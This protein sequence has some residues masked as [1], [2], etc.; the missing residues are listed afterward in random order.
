MKNIVQVVS[1]I[2][3]KNASLFCCFL[4]RSLSDCSYCKN[5]ASMKSYSYSQKLP[6]KMNGLFYFILF[7]QQREKQVEVDQLQY[8]LGAVTRRSQTEAAGLRQK[9]SDLELQLVEARKEADEYYRSNLERNSEVTAL[10]Q[11]VLAIY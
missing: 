8:D 11:E 9:V 5:L 6:L 10:G 4:I 2:H 3:E 1:K 7:G